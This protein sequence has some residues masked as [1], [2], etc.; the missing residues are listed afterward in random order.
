MSSLTAL[1]VLDCSMA[2][3]DGAW[4]LTR[5]QHLVIRSTRVT[6]DPVC[7]AR[8]RAWALTPSQ[9][10]EAFDI[11]GLVLASSQL[12]AALSHVEQ[13]NVLRIVVSIACNG[14]QACVDAFSTTRCVLDLT[15]RA[16]TMCW[17]KGT[18]GCVQY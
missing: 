18:C 7:A 3:S 1:Q 6:L 5:L 2:S 16:C 4:H 8:V 17:S 14:A 15:S 13:S 12:R 11:S 9:C 10:L